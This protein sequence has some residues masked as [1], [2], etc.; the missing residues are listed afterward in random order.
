MLGTSPVFSRDVFV[1]VEIFR[2]CL[3]CLL[4]ILESDKS[5]RM[6]VSH[7]RKKQ[8]KEF[9]AGQLYGIVS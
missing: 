6:H 4:F 7:T 5:Q 8:K 2:E 1:E 9:G 3:D